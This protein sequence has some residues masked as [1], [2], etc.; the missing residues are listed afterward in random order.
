MPR[1]PLLFTTTLVPAD[2]ASPD[3]SDERCSLGSLLTDPDGIVLAG[4]AVIADINI[5]TSGGKIE[6][7]R[8]SQR[9]VYRPPTP[10][11][12]GR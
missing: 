11:C 12:R 3:S 10:D 6:P 8:R 1:R 7:R 9:D 2:R 5:A 4:S